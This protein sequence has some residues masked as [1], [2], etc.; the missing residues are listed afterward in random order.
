MKGWTNHARKRTSETQ[1]PE[2]KYRE[3]R[4]PD[5][6]RKEDGRENEGE[7]SIDV[8]VSKMIERKMF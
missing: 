8:K 6:A 5:M 7:E 4:R 2:D 3:G 1:Q